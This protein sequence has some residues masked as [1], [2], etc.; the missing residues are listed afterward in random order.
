MLKPYEGNDDIAVKGRKAV[1]SMI[2]RGFMSV[3]ILGVT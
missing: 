3:V 2:L 1:L